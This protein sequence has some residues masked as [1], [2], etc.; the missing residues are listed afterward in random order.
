MPEFFYTTASNNQA[1]Q[2][3][4]FRTEPVT[5]ALG[6]VVWQEGGQEN[7]TDALLPAPQNPQQHAPQ[8]SGQISDTAAQEERSEEEMAPLT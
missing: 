7:A 4:H 1:R 5:G 2:S 6:G 3:P 8:H